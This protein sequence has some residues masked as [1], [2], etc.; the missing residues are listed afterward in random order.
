[1][2]MPES[3]TNSEEV[4]SRLTRKLDPGSGSSNDGKRTVL[5][6]S[7]PRGAFLRRTRQSLAICVLLL[8]IIFYLWTLWNIVRPLLTRS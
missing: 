2:Q 4:S 1:M 7:E 8:Q 6:L 3:P 5:L